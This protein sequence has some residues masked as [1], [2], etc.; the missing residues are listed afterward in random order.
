VSLKQTGIQRKK[1]YC[2]VRLESWS[3]NIIDIV[4]ERIG[5]VANNDF[6]NQTT[7][8]KLL[9]PLNPHGNFGSLQE[10]IPVQMFV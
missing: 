9:T 1:N 10:D 6:Q 7:K 8:R 4:S 2:D 3:D 5:C